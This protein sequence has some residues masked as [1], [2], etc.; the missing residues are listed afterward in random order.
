G[1]N[2]YDEGGYLIQSSQA[3]D[4]QVF[5]KTSYN[6]IGWVIAT[7]RGYNTSGTSWEQATTPS[8]DTIFEQAENTYDELGNVVSQATF[9]RLN[10]A[11]DV[12]PLS[13]SS[14]P[15][16]RVSYTANWFDGIDRQIASANYGA[17]GTFT[18]PTTPPASSDTVL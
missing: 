5:S 6:N 8:N 1:N 12:G 14:Q 7:Y 16:A 4:G 17:I 15:M 11:T 10:D 13:G 18:R 2:W 9:Q 3:G